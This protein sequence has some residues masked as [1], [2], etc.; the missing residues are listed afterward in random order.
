MGAQSTRQAFGLDMDSY[1]NMQFYTW[2]D[3][4]TFNAG[5]PQE[6]WVHIALTYDGSSVRVYTQ[7]QLRATK[8]YASGLN[9][10]SNGIDIGGLSARGWYFDGLIDEMGVYSRALT[11]AEV[12]FIYAAGA[13]GK[14]NDFGNRGFGIQVTGGATNNTI[15]GDTPAAANV[16]A[17]NLNDGVNLSG[18]TSPSGTV[19]WWRAE[20]TAADAVDGNA[21]TLMN[22]ATYG[23]GEFRQGFSFDGVDDYVNVPNSA[24]LQLTSASAST[25]SSWV[26]ARTLPSNTFIP[27]TPTKPFAYGMLYHT[28]RTYCGPM[29]MTEPAGCTATS[30]SPCNRTGSTT[31][32]RCGPGPSWP[33]TWTASCSGPGLRPWAGSSRGWARCTWASGT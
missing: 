7:G 6:G 16:I 32:P 17:G 12:Q 8:A 24:N 10:V 28:A 22:G 13:A 19:S 31:S 4:I 23:S 9:T 30:A 29:F 14:P 26:M 2:A 11:D 3:D 18:T 25:V 21:G 15:G 5:V 20:G 33:C 27:V 1:P